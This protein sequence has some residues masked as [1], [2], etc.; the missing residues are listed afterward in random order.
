M[1]EGVSWME[2]MLMSLRKGGPGDFTTW[3]G[4]QSDQDGMFDFVGV[5]SM[6]QT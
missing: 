5:L 3:A 6:L 2:S 1:M 4:R